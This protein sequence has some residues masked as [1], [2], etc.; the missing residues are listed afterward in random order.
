[1]KQLSIEEFEQLKRD[2]CIVVDVRNHSVFAE[3]FI[4]GS[5]NFELNDQF[6]K[7]TRLF[8]FKDQSIMLV[9]D[10]EPV[11]TAFRILLDA[12][13]SNLKGCLKGGYKNW[14][15]AGKSIDVV[16]SIDGEELGLDQKYSPKELYDIRKAEAYN[17]RHV[18]GAKSLTVAELIKNHDLIDNHNPVCIYCHDGSLS[19]TL[20]SYLKSNGKYNIFHIKGGFSGIESDQEIEFD[21]VY[22]PNNN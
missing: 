5:L 22:T 12:G 3:S 9:G 20:I 11:E 6:L 13:Y 18:K 10:K 4:P 19:M 16:I 2:G 14:A 15:N 8:L 1:M 17:K 7:N 21:F